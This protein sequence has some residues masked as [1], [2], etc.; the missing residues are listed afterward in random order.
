V[1]RKPGPQHLRPW[2]DVIEEFVGLL[3]MEKQKDRLQVEHC[4][5]DRTRVHAPALLGL[6]HALPSVPARFARE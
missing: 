3:Q 6:G 1:A 2:G 5:R 4:D